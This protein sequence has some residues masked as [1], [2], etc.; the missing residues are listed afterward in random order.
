VGSRSVVMRT[1]FSDLLMCRPV[2]VRESSCLVV[3][4]V[5]HRFW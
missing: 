3:I 5:H 4:R 1:V 2:L